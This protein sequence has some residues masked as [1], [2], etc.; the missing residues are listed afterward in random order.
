MKSFKNTFHGVSPLKKHVGETWFGEQIALETGHCFQQLGSKK[1]LVIADKGIRQ[2]E[3]INAVVKSIETAG[4]QTVVYNEILPSPTDVK[5][6][7]VA[8]ISRTEN[9]DGILGIGGGSTIDVAKAASVLQTNPGVA[10]DYLLNGGK[11]RFTE[12][13]KA[14]LVLV[15]TTAGAGAELTVLSAVFNTQE[16]LKD[17]MMV[18]IFADMILLDP[19]LTVTCSPFFTYISAMDALSHS[20]ERFT[21]KGSNPRGNMIAGQCIE[22][23]WRSLPKV[24]ENPY[25]LNARG[26]LL[27]ASHYCMDFTIEYMS[28]RANLNHAIAGALGYAYHLDHGHAV[29][30]ALPAYMR[31]ISKSRKVDKECKIISQKMGLDYS[32][33]GYGFAVAEAIAAFNQKM[34]L[35]TLKE[36]GISLESVYKIQPQILGAW[37]ARVN[38]TVVL[39]T[40]EQI[41]NILNDIY[42]H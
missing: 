15:P 7:E 4:A 2:L 6:D 29:A 24:L 27:L 39:P 28:A 38:N 16:R 36:Q 8:R 33:K 14:K 9:V 26:E 1:V 41:R 10:H 13:P 32:D 18:D 22:F 21:N 25:D 17:N 31:F 37:R 35:P 42:N 30:M 11:K 3:S 23:I 12:L 40:K 19:C 34:K 20:I 5:I